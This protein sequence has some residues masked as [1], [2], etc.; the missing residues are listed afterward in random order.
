MLTGHYDET[1]LEYLTGFF[2]KDSFEEVQFSFYIF[3]IY[4]VY[5]KNG[6]VFCRAKISSS[7][8]LF[9]FFFYSLIY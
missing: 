9:Y 2:D 1:T 7:N 6:Y 5:K 4:I 8:F 3:C